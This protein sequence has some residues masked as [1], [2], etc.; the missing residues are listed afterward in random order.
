MCC[1]FPLTYFSVVVLIRFF[2][3][4]SFMVSSYKVSSES[5]VSATGREIMG[6]RS[7]DGFVIISDWVKLYGAVSHLSRSKDSVNVTIGIVGCFD[8]II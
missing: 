4:D 5:T 1:D 8:F 2:F 3:L 7:S 6:L